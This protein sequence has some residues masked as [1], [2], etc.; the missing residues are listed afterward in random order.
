MP[1]DTSKQNV[2]LV[3]TAPDGK[4]WNIGTRSGGGFT[5]GGA[6]QAAA[7]IETL[8]GWP[9]KPVSISTTMEGV[10]EMVRHKESLDE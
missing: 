6:R 3:V 4:T 2:F 7:E 10:I 5:E 1:R 9:V 8:T